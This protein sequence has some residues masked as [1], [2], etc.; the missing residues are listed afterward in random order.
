MSGSRSGANG[1]DE[2][3]APFPVARAGKGSRGESTRRLPEMKC[4]R[5]GL[6]PMAPP[7]M[8]GEAS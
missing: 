5:G 3:A 7:E 4:E 2:I 1:S 6:E 8:I